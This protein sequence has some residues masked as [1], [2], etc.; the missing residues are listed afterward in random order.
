MRPGQDEARDAAIETKTQMTDPNGG[1]T[2][3][4]ALIRLE[5]GQSEIRSDVRGIR[6]DIGRLADTDTED[7]EASRIEHGRLWEELRRLG[8]RRRTT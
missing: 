8:G 4:A 5:A 6:H 3:R 7:R 1:S 2:I